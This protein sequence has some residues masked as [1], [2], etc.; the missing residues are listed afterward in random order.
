M[1]GLS[2]FIDSCSHRAGSSSE[3]LPLTDGLDQQQQQPWGACQNVRL[4]AP[5]PG[6]AGQGLHFNEIP[7]DS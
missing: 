3:T 2:L 5:H 6:L 1:K 4:P 7:G